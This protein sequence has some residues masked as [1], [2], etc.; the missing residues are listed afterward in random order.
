MPHIKLSYYDKPDLPNFGDDLAPKLVQHITGSPVVHAGHADAELFAVGSILGFWDS[1]RKAVARRLKELF[2]GQQPLAVWGT[3]LIRP[4]RVM[5]P[6]C[7]VL[8]LRG[9]LSQ[10][11]AGLSHQEILLG[12][13]GILAK[14]LIGPVEKHNRIGI[15]PHYVDKAHPIIQELRK[16]AEYQVIDVE[17]ECSEV[18]QDIAGCCVVLS[19]SLHGL[20]VADSYGIP[21]ARLVLSDKIIGGDFKFDDYASGVERS[22]IATFRPVTVRDLS[23][24]PSCIDQT[25]DCADAACIAEKS[26][27][28]A[29][30]LRK[31]VMTQLGT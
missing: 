17:R 31:W 14:D 2:Q 7:H 11:Y 27:S 12:D 20:V 13:P 29:T 28:L 1:R 23:Q 16:H 18:C 26:N 22:R 8:A 19:S 21:N 15:V 24:I 4:K 6:T 25:N 30:V 5:L 3:G 10:Q 9:R